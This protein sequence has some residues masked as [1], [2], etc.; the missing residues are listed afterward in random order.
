MLLPISGE[1]CRREK[2]MA[3][4]NKSEFRTI[5]EAGVA[6]E[7]E[8]LRRKLRG[9]LDEMGQKL[10]GEFSSKF[11]YFDTRYALGSW[12]YGEIPIGKY[13]VLASRDGIA[14]R[15]VGRRDSNS[16][17]VLTYV[18]ENPEG[19]ATAIP[20]DV[21]TAPRF[22]SDVSAWVGRK[23]RRIINFGTH[24]GVR[25]R[26]SIYFSYCD[27]PILALLHDDARKDSRFGIDD[28]VRAAIKLRLHHSGG[29]II[30]RIRYEAARKGVS[31]SRFAKD[32]LRLFYNMED[33]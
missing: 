11:E 13:I 18:S 12:E 2:G 27:L 25:N 4:E 14:H 31:M 15:L 21:L 19:P 28:Y 24:D 23:V 16:Y 8:P 30:E 33:L 32:T 6:R 10:E 3:M 7:L 1:K 5:D 17:S 22:A 29:E 20:H 9:P 26:L